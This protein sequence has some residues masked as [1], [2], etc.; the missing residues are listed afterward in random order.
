MTAMT[1][2]CPKPL[3]LFV[4]AML[5]IVGCGLL[6][7]GLA[8][9]GPSAD[10]S[11]YDPALDGL[12]LL[13]VNPGVVV[14][15]SVLVLK[16]RSFVGA[17]WGT[18]SIL[19]RGTFDNGTESYEVDFR[20]TVRFVDLET[21]EIDVDVEFLDAL[22]SNSGEFSG[23]IRVDID[24][25]VDTNRHSS[26]DLEASLSVRS[27][28]TP[29]DAT[30]RANGPVYVNDNVL[31]EA[32]GLLLGGNE[33]RSYARVSG[34]FVT[35]GIGACEPI[36][37]RELEVTPA[38]DFDRTQG[39]FA[40]APEIAGIQSGRFEGEV[41]I[42][43]RH[44]SERDE[45]SA[46]QPVEY[47]LTE[48]AVFS[49][50]SPVVSIGQYLE[51]AGAGFVE[52][53]Q[54]SST[55]LELTGEY[56]PLEGR[57]TS[58]DLILVPEFV[59]GRRLRYTLSE[60]DALGQL[61]DLRSAQGTFAGTVTAQVSHG[62]ESVVGDPLEIQVDLAP[63]K[64]VVYLNFTSQY[65]DALR[66]FGLR[67]T[68]AA[69]RERVLAAVRRDYR[70][71]NID[72]RLEEPSDFS[73]YS[74]VDIGGFDP[75]G[76]GLLGYDNTPGKDSGNE[77]LHDH[78]GG[79][80]A[81][82]QEDGFPGYGGVFIESFFI[83]SEHPGE[84]APSVPIA[85]P[86]FDEIFDPFRPD[87][88][89]SPVR[90]ADLSGGVALPPDGLGCPATERNGQIGCAAWTLANLIAS[91]VSHEIGHSLGLANP[92]G[93]SSHHASDAP[94][95]MMD[96]GSYR[97]FNERAE[98]SQAGPADFCDEAYAYLRQILPTDE[99]DDSLGRPLCF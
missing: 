64:Q 43:N 16:G 94:R 9:C 57:P 63:V 45:A 8:G 12:S 26:P 71:I 36:E 75:N 81:S 83:F 20:K 52:T 35:A 74:I 85:D 91:T 17:P 59:E 33:G 19:V 77:R 34:C 31:V 5:R 78:I 6:G 47:E 30:V 56:T 11:R 42:I 48:S 67:A 80:N 73:L 14:P 98:L 55:I 49:I 76:L 25:A 70:T 90:A 37:T 86:L 2:L 13:E 60:D 1:A 99:A 66:A 89:G 62:A 39:N 41:T 10:G 93:G 96:S 27:F 88:G 87:R 61:L 51:I 28:L 40:F 58:L 79:V 22:G 32:S 18:P 44:A 7:Y 4:V 46:A 92:E 24:S 68:D 65:V 15:G 54:D 82:T 21:L 72:F 53:S 29:Q 69:I 23:T 84:F 97:P 95:R 50:G 3:S 38:T